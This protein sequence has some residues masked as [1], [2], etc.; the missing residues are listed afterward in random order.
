MKKDLGS[1]RKQDKHS[2]HAGNV[3]KLDK[4]VSLT[5]RENPANTED[6]YL[7]RLT[8]R[9]A[10]VTASSFLMVSCG[11][12]SQSANPA[13]PSSQGILNG[14][15]HATATSHWVATSC[16]VQVELTADGKAWTVVIDTSGTTSSG[17]ETWTAGA[18]SSSISIGPGT[19]QGGFFWVS[20]LTNI[21]GTTASEAFSADVTVG[22]STNTHQDLGTCSFTLQTGPLS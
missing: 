6:E 12:G 15:T 7:S 21:K 8:L 1:P 9:I 22:D 4:Y 14:Q 10:A 5:R 19:G 17:A 11:S 2:V 18:S 13:P 3:Y 16:G 20:A